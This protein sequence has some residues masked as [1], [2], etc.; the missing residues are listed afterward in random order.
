MV[1]VT[2]VK[3]DFT[4]GYTVKKLEDCTDSNQFGKSKNSYSF[5]TYI[6]LN[7]GTSFYFTLIFASVYGSIFLK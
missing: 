5:Q 2:I 1:C 7:E 3:F 4:F 6:T